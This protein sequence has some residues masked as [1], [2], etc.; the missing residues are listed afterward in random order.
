MEVTP[1]YAILTA[2]YQAIGGR[3]AYSEIVASAQLVRGLEHLGFEAELIPAR[4]NVFRLSRG[5]AG[6]TE[7]NTWDHPQTTSG[8]G[9]TDKNLVVWAASFN[10]CV[11]LSMCQNEV[12][13][14]A[15]V[16]GEIFTF[17]VI[18]PMPGGLEQLLHRADLIGAERPPFKISWKFFP[19]WKPQFDSVLAHYAATIEH[20]GLALAHVVVDLLSASAVHR[21][22]RQIEDLYP[23]L[24]G[25]LSGGVHLP[26][27]HDDWSHHEP[28]ADCPPEF[29]MKQRSKLESL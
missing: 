17:P 11:D 4:T 25:L 1:L 29:T 21:D 7:A 19:E 20:G 15:S 3:A 27:L 14:R 22:L 24:G 9:A 18:L 10:R 13:K 8:G 23:R 6:V 5:G 12:L 28:C 26:E 16:N 2:A